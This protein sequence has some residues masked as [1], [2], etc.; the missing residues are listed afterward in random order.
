VR[1]YHFTCAHSRKRILD[2]HT[3]RPLSTSYQQLIWLTDLEYPDVRGLGLTSFMLRCD[4][5]EYRCTVETESAVKWTDWA[6]YA[7]VPLNIRLMLD[8]VDGAR[9][10][11]WWVSTVPVPIRVIEPTPERR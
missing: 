3:L 10:L 4:R 8:H 7:K 11:N 2:D 9:P 5:T 6:H 1:L